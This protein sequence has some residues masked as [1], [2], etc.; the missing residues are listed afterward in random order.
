MDINLFN[1]ILNQIDFYQQKAFYSGR[2]ITEIINFLLALTGVYFFIISQFIV[3]FKEIGENELLLILIFLFCITIIVF[4]ITFF[5]NRIT[6][7]EWKMIRFC[8]KQEKQVLK[9][10][11]DTYKLNKNELKIKAILDKRLIT[12]HDDDIPELRESA[13]K[14]QFSINSIIFSFF[15][16]LVLFLLYKILFLK[17]IIV[18]NLYDEL[19][20]LVI[21]VIIFILIALLYFKKMIPSMDMSE[22]EIK[23]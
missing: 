13:K 23:K 7:R 5:I 20:I 15:L 11:L 8:R 9:N 10:L 6:I 1:I 12:I 17:G 18:I 16:T 19:T 3:I 22:I 4:L 14:A 2:K 21:F